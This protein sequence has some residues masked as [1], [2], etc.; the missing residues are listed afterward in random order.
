M[1]AS[2]DMCSEAHRNWFPMD[3]SPTSHILPVPSCT[4]VPL[5]LPA[6]SP[7]AWGTLPLAD[8]RHLG[9]ATLDGAPSPVGTVP[10]AQLGR[11]GIHLSQT[12]LPGFTFRLS[13][14]HTR[15]WTSDRGRRKA[16][17]VWWADSVN[18]H[19]TFPRETRLKGTPYC[20]GII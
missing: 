16:G 10:I 14:S 11:S 6:T 12:Q 20:Q 5:L 7:G 19:A 8:W 2:T 3:F 15:K 1:S 4:P 17:E 13:L 9:A 18:T